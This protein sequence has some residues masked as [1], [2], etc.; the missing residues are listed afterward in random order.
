VFVSLNVHHM[1]TVPSEARRAR[2]TSGCKLPFECL[3]PNLGP[4]EEQV[5]LIAEL[6]LQFPFLFIK[7]KY[8]IVILIKYTQQLPKER[9]TLLEEKMYQKACFRSNLVLLTGRI[10]SINNEN[11]IHWQC[12]KQR[13]TS[14]FGKVLIRC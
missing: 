8:M 5:L 14:S 4:L 10:N 9:K 12:Y 2:A 1:C 13:K 7:G 3:Q 6:S 11:K